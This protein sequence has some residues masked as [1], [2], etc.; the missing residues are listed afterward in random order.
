MVC[1]IYRR[2]RLVHDPSKKKV[3]HDLS[4]ILPLAELHATP[5]HSTPLHCTPLHCTPLHC[6]PL[7]RHVWKGRALTC[8][9]PLRSALLSRMHFGCVVLCCLLY[10]VVLLLCCIVLCCCCIVLLLCCC[11]I[12]LCCCYLVVVLCCV[13][14]VLCCVV[15][16]LLLYCIVVVVL[17]CILLLLLCCIVLCCCVVLYCVVWVRCRCG[18]Q[19]AGSNYRRPFGC[20]VLSLCPGLETQLGKEFAPSPGVPIYIPNQEEKFPIM[21]QCMCCHAPMYVC[22]APLYV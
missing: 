10:C 20:A 1:F 13:V 3:S 6:T 7:Q 15:V 11:C 5:L 18:A 8:D 4:S 14:V 12:V 2:G 17:Y 9:M 22:H 19:D 16:I 21:H